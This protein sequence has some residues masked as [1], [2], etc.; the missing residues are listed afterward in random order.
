LPVVHRTLVVGLVR[1]YSSQAAEADEQSAVV[2]CL[3]ELQETEV[4]AVKAVKSRGL[5]EIFGEVVS[6]VDSGLADADVNDGGSV[7]HE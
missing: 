2:E 7:G 5:P 1:S 6:K 3:L 4:R